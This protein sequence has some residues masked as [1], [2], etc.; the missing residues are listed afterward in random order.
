MNNSGYRI[1]FSL[2][3]LFVFVSTNSHA[4]GRKYWIFFNDKGSPSESALPRITEKSLDRRSKTLQKSAL[5]DDYDLNVYQPYVEALISLDIVPIRTSNWLNGV[6]AHL[7]DTQLILVKRFDFVS[8]IRPVARYIGTN[9]DVS[10][11]KSIGKPMENAET[12]S[13][14]GLS[15]AQNQL[16]RVPEIHDMGITGSGVVIGLLDSGFNYK[17]H[18]AFSHLDVIAEYDFVNDD[19]VTAKEADDNDAASQHSHGTNVLSAIAGYQEEELIGPAHGASYLLAKTEDVRSETVVEED[20][21]VAGIEWMERL[22]ADIVSSSLGYNDWYT[23]EDMDGETAITTVAADIAFS[24]G[25]VVLNSLGNEGNKA[26]RYMIAP[27]DARGV[28]GVGAVDENGDLSSFSSYGPTYDGRIKP[29]VVAM[30][31]SVYVVSPS[32]TN[33]YTYSNG[34]SLA[35]PLVAGVAGLLLSA[36]PDY[37]ASQVMSVLKSTASR[38]G[39]PDNAYGWGIVNAYSALF[40]EEPDLPDDFVLYEN[41]PNPFNSG[42]T[43]QYRLTNGGEISLKIYNILGQLVRTLADGYQ[44]AGTHRVRWDGTNNS[45]I[46]A[47]SGIYLYILQYSDATEIRKMTFLK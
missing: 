32:T 22:G 2:L 44:P 27:A 46:R 8:E 35:C 16:M 45:N 31:S 14:Y 29:D 18:D 7:S 38:A 19:S 10:L 20:N 26:W 28:I 11:N 4:V 37:T 36:H 25:I 6:S 3:T 17:F 43:I 13:T 41:Y 21:W 40:T 47:S 24:K 42:T 1:I 5:T 39:A 33:Q 12:A 15:Y 30:G 23:Y 9:S 34:T